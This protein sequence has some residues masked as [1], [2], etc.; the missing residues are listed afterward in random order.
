MRQAVLGRWQ[1]FM[2]RCSYCGAEYP[3]EAA[4]CA[5]DGTP[6]EEPEAPS[7]PGTRGVERLWIPYLVLCSIGAGISILWYLTH[8]QHMSATMPAWAII[9]FRFIVFLR[10][11]SIVAMWWDSRSG[12]VAYIAL[13]A[14]GICVNLAIGYTIALG[15][16]IGIVI[17]IV[18]VRP[19][20]QHM[21]WAVE[22]PVD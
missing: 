16:I 6:F 4:V 14:I 1:H 15:G 12:V 3:D 13:S 5:T 11:L 9:V 8:W 10:P 2:K 7:K 21:I 22:M 17:F 19:R 20:W 18:L